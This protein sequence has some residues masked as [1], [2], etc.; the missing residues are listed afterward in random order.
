MS[1][2]DFARFYEQYLP[3]HAALKAQLEGAASAERFIEIA[4]A[5]G[6]KAGF[7]FT[8]TEVQQVMKTR[9]GQLSDNQL[10]GVAGGRGPWGWRW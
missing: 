9:T 3:K 10:A 7:S 2:E 4:V 1:K 8:A 6:P 5:E